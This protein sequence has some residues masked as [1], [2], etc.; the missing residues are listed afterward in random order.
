[1]K[2]QFKVI[3]FFLCVL[4]A[5]CGDIF[6]QWYT[7]PTY[8]EYV[9]YMEKWP[10]DY[11]QLAKLYDLGSAGQAS[12][13][14]RVYAMRISDNVGQD[15]QEP[16][17]LYT[18]TIHG[19]EVLGYMSMLHLI[20]TLLVSYGKDALITNLIDSVDIWIAPNCNPDGT[21][22]R[23]DYTVEQAQRRNVADNFDLN[24][25][26]PCPCGN[27]QYG[28]YSYF[29]KEIEAIKGVI[30]SNN[31][32]LAGDVHGGT[33]AIIYPWCYT[34]S[35]H[36]PD[37]EWFNYVGAEYLDTVWEY[38][39]NN[40]YLTGGI[41][42]CCNGTFE[43]HGAPIDYMLYFN[44]CRSI[45]LELSIRKLLDESDLERLWGYNYRS[46]L[47][48][49]KQVLY[50]I[51]GT[52]T[53]ALTGE[54]LNAQ[55]FIDNHDTLNSHVYS[56]LPHGDYYRPIYEGTYDVTFSC[57]GYHSKTI[58]GVQVENNKATVLD[59]QLLDISTDI[60]FQ[61]DNLQAISIDICKD[62][63]KINYHSGI[64]NNKLFTLEIYNV[65][66]RRLY[67]LSDSYKNTGSYNVNWDNEKFSSGV[68]Y[69]KLFSGKDT[70]IRKAVI[71]K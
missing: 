5:L 13:S 22:P 47:N 23:G 21:Y 41:I 37:E 11:P 67:S 17:F 58:T 8:P 28:L 68:Y 3:F 27:H 62:R 49:I 1:M 64:P 2:L 36:P 51:R 71:V 12:L 24:R 42:P 16:S 66:G 19:D 55:V 69:I 29:A 18:S 32:V 34:D 48:Y 54:P 46:L 38:C 70:L 10:M 40:G 39:Q 57:D 26:F 33:E 25:N 52:V 14:H 35:S 44:H 53:D 65:Y 9:G 45:C 43:S 60:L 63:I 31:F 50:G 6:S 30:D 56:H 15:E 4:C 7:Y 59:V 61:D 20:D